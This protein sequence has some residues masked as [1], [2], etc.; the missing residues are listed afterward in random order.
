M[1]PV[2][3]LPLFYRAVTLVSSAGA[4]GL[5]VTTGWQEWFRQVF[6]DWG[7]LGLSL[8]FSRLPFSKVDRWT[9]Q[10]CLHM[11]PSLEP[12]L[13]DQYLM[14]VGTKALEVKEW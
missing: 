9:P 11:G 13:E 14:W 2:G 10:E 7:F 12:A 1:L 3:F 5:T 8:V 4:T 6:M